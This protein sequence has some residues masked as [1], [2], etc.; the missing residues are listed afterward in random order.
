MEPWYRKIEAFSRRK[1]V[2]I[3]LAIVS[4]IALPFLVRGWIYSAR[5]S[6]TW[7]VEQKMSA[8]LHELQN[9]SPGLERAEKYLVRL[10]AIKTGYAPDDL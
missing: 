10:K 4:L 8:A 5:Q 1:S 7:D 6:N 9:S 3:P 2:Q